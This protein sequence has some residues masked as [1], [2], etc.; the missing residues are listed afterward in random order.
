MSGG[1]IIILVM[2]AL[3]VLYPFAVAFRLKGIGAMSCSK[4][5]GCEKV[6]SPY[7]VKIKGKT[8]LTRQSMVVKLTLKKDCLFLKL[9]WGAPRCI[10]LNKI[11]RA[12]RLITGV[13]TTG[14][15]FL[16]KPNSGTCEFTI[17]GIHDVAPFVSHLEASGIKCTDVL[18]E[19]KL[20]GF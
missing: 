12:E 9:L 4:N 18:A 16:P 10:A 14:I 3:F 2:V 17:S 8:T 19:R 7:W 6:L 1:Y 5:C 20:F 11:E 13:K 15:R